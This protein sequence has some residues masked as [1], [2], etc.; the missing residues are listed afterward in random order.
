MEGFRGFVFW[1][2]FPAHELSC[3]RFPLS[4][5]CRISFGDKLMTA[6]YRL[7]SCIRPPTNSLPTFIW[8]IEGAVGSLYVLTT[9]FCRKFVICTVGS[10]PGVSFQWS[11]SVAYFGTDV[12]FAL[13][14]RWHQRRCY[15]RTRGQL[16]CALHWKALRRRDIGGRPVLNEKGKDSPADLGKVV[17]LMQYVSPWVS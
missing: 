2:T 6:I 3:G 14:S 12:S 15:E 17:N 4:N 11:L 5:H 7:R 8:F 10:L 13:P 9:H 16:F 1:L